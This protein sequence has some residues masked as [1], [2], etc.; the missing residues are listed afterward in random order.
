MTDFFMTAQ[1]VNFVDPREEI[2]ALLL[3]SAVLYA[4]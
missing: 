4:V 1:L 2:L 3:V